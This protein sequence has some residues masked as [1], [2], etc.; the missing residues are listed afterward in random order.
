MHY[1]QRRKLS[2][3][4]ANF[5]DHVARSYKETTVIHIEAR[6]HKPPYA[7]RIVCNEW[8]GVPYR[9]GKRTLLTEPGEMPSVWIGFSA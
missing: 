3:A 1:E 2:P 4:T 6:A 7:F 8:K 9:I 5:F